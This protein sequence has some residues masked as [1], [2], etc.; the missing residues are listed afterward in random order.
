MR[1][2]LTLLLFLVPLM[3]HAQTDAEKSW[4]KW[5]EEEDHKLKTEP[6][7]YLNV[8]DAAYLNKG[9]TVYLRGD[10]KSP[11]DYKWSFKAEKNPLAKITFD[12]KE[13]TVERAGAAPYD[14]LKQPL[15][16]VNPDI[17]IEGMAPG[18]G[19]ARVFIHNL[20][21]PKVVNFKAS[22]FWPYNPA[23]VVTGT[24]KRQQPPEQV[25]FR[26][27]RK[28]QKSLYLVGRIDFKIDQ[29]D[30]SLNVYSSDSDLKK[31]NFFLVWFQDATSGHGSYRA[32]REMELTEKTL[33]EDGAKVTLD[34]NRLTNPN[35]ARSTFYN[36]L[37][38]RDPA[39]K[40]AITAG[41]MDPGEHH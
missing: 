38:V 30:N 4:K 14:M 7:S 24:F 15:W 34:F 8:N 2:L 40:S 28:L 39:L 25:T 33:P 23:M 21:H 36:C 10:F 22:K 5:I 3:T 31:M 27:E 13:L 26:T 37:V 18:D 12:G 16:Q 11:N 6:K 29:H 35:C 9:Q 1:I 20:K 41:E 32:A 19:I 17:L